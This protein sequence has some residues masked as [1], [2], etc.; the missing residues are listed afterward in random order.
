MAMCPTCGQQMPQIV[1]PDQ[2]CALMHTESREVYK[3]RDGLWYLTKGG[4]PVSD[5]VVETLQRAGRIRDKYSD[6]PNECFTT[7]RTIDM[8]ATLAS[9]KSKRRQDWRTVYLDEGPR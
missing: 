1:D 9:R 4:G 5:W 8:P 6:I 3:G 7:G 2:L